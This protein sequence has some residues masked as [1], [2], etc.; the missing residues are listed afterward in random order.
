MVLNQTTTFKINGVTP[1]RIYL[2]KKIIWPFPEYNL[3]SS[4]GA[5]D[6]G[7]T[8]T[9]T[10]STLNVA[11]VT[12]IPYIITGTGISAADFS[13]GFLS[14]N[15]LIS[16]NTGSVS[17]TASNDLL[18]EGVE[19]MTLSASNKTCTVSINDTSTTPVTMLNPRYITID[20]S[21]NLYV[22]EL[23]RHT[24]KKIDTSGIM[25]IFAGSELSGTTNGS[26]LEARFN[27][28]RGMVFDSSGNMYVCDSG[29]HVIRKISSNGQVTTHVGGMGVSGHV[30]DVLLNARFNSPVDLT[31]A[32]TNLYVLD[33]LNYRIRKVTLAGTVT[34][35]AGNGSPAIKN[36]PDGYTAGTTQVKTLEYIGYVSSYDRV[37][38]TDYDTSSIVRFLAPSNNV[39]WSWFHTSANFNR[40]LTGVGYDA[41]IADHNR[42]I[43]SVYK[44]TG[45]S[46]ATVIAGSTTTGY[47]DGQGTAAR[48]NG[49]FGIVK[50]SSNNIYA[51]DG[52]HKIRKITPTGAVTTVI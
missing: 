41:W 19:Y 47:V 36:S 28:P 24:I 27:L 40:G 48:F 25:T 13:A 4:A 34:S 50:D 12:L 18:T 7:S 32:G 44:S 5:I 23:N 45:S 38:F 31:L 16:N 22:T 39:V 52:N 8:V 37:V 21:G 14:G 3:Y 42:I 51:C 33:R 6:E 26:L 20:S 10:L 43:K 30:N 1:S 49:I 46:T 11:D 17:L 2:K 15:F 29:N 9:F 35:V